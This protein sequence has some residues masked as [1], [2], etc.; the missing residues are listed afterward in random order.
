MTTPCP[1]IPA[2]RGRILITGGAGTLGRALMRESERRGW[3]AE[4][5]IYSRGE[6]LQAQTRALF[7]RA[8]YTLGDVRDYD[9]LAAAVQGHDLVIHAA[10]MKRIPECE[11]HPSECLATNVTGSLNVARACAAAGAAAVAISTDK[12]CRASTLYGASKLAM[13]GIFR[14]AARRTGLRMTLVRYGNVVA[15]RGSVIPLWRQQHAAGQPLTITDERMTR[16]WMSEAD[17]VELVAMAAGAPSGSILVPQM[18]AMRVVD[19]ASALFPI[20]RMAVI[21]LRSDEKLHEDLVHEDEPAVEAAGHYLIHSPSATRGHRYTSEL[22]P[23]LTPEAFLEMLTLA[24]AA[25]G[26]AR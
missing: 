3:D 25:E 22:A 18:G 16:F 21:G 9:R 10:A 14:E 13:E 15:S 23:R 1:P 6:L 7:P 24:E 26:V 12:A 5:T 2:L 19:M 17:A 20:A 4:F 8:R 11:A